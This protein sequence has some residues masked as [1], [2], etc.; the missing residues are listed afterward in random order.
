MQP[1]AP[2]HPPLDPTRPPTP[3]IDLDALGDQI[4]ELAAHIG[5]A[6]YRLLELI[7]EFDAREGWA[8]GFKSCAHWL[9]WRTGI[10]LGASREKVRVAR[11]LGELPLL[12]EA[13]ARGELSYSKIRALTRVATAATEEE[14]LGFARAGTTAHV[15]KLVRSWRR[16]RRLEEI[17]RAN[18][19]HERRSLS[20]FFDEDGMLVLRGRLDAE[21]GELLVRA[22][23]AAEEELYRQRRAEQEVSRKSRTTTPSTPPRTLLPS[24]AA[25]T[26][27]PCSPRAR[28]AEGS[29]RASRA[30]TAPP[31]A[32]RWWSTSTARASTRRAATAGCWRAG[33]AFQLKR[34][35][36]SPATPGA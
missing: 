10:D 11:A 33:N 25:P 4:A 20:F 21:V 1:T 23:E 17:E 12:S 22:L 24:S 35:A 29:A 2:L 19:C 30:G 15:E 16:C 36:G 32:T 6:T 9:S 13:M 31:T 28:S 14:L 26:R 18:S 7:R 34:V 5:A 8:C 27:S 3:P